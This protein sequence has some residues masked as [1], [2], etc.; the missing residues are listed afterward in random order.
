MVKRLA[1]ALWLGAAL[2]APAAAFGTIDGLGQHTEHE[3]ITRAALVRAG[4]DRETLDSLAGRKGTFGAVGA[5]DRPDRGLLGEAA[6]HC[7]G[8]DHLDIAGYPQDAATAAR[9]LEACK[10]WKLKALGDAVAAAGRIV[11]EGTRAIDDDQIPEYIGCVF[12]GSSGRAK[13]DV[14]EALGLAFHVGQ[15]FY[16][17]TNWSDA[18]APDQGGPDNPPGLGHEGAAPWIDPVA[19]PG[20]AYPGGLISGCFEGIPESL[21]CTYGAGLDRVRHAVLNKDTGRIDRATGAAGPG[22]TPRGAAHGNFERA[23]AA[24][25]A[26]TRNAFAHFEAETLRVYGPERGALILCAV[27]ADDPDDCR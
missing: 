11:P 4:L 3:E 9:A 26:D 19:G 25:I 6:A 5:P 21:H 7:D 17:H 22:E 1:V 2:S 15:D 14:L 23:V 8:G 24:A 18:A 13:C 20:G 10:A 27:K 12:D 16:A